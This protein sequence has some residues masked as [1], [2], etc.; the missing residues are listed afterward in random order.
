MI[1]AAVD[2]FLVTDGQG[3][4]AKQQIT[5]I[6]ICFIKRAAELK[7]IEHLRVD[8]F[9]KQQVEGFVGKKLWRQG[10]RAIGKPQ[11]I[12]DHPGHGFARCDLLL[13]VGDEACIDHLNQT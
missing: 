8:A 3:E 4:F 5:A 2:A 9:T 10:Q 1:E 6:S 13:C 7:A 11:A 12:E